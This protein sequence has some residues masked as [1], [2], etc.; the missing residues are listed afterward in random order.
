M[1]QAGTCCGLRRACCL[2]GRREAS[3]QM[4]GTRSVGLYADVDAD[5]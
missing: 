3:D 2:A 4:Q 1:D 5:C